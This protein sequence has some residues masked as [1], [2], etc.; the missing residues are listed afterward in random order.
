[1]V[2][3]CILIFVYQFI[4]LIVTCVM[5]DH[6]V[7]NDNKFKSSNRNIGKKYLYFSIWGHLIWPLQIIKFLMDKNG[8]C[9]SPREEDYEKEKQ[10]PRPVIRPEYLKDRKRKGRQG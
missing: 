8:N 6:Y 7:G 9:R 4:G 5:I 10:D 1:M 3:I 2:G